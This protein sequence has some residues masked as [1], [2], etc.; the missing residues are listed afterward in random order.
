MEKSRQLIAFLFQRSGKE[1]LNDNDIY[2]A[3][4]YE[5]GWFTPG[6][7]KNFIKDCM[8][9]ELLKKEE[10]G[11]KPNFDYGAVELPLGFRAEG[12]TTRNEKPDILSSIVSEIVKKGVKEGDAMISIKNLAE[13]EKIIPEVAAIVITKKHRIDVTPFLNDVWDVIKNM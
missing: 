8:D 3:L 10:D 7:A 1:K 6:Q 9:K 5:L 4:S 13:K 11:Y 12:G 2:M